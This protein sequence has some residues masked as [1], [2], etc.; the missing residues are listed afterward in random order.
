MA[1]ILLVRHG[2]TDQVSMRLSGRL[3]GILLNEKGRLQAAALAEQLSLAPLLALYSSPLERALQTAAPLAERLGLS[4][5]LLPWL[6]EVDYGTWQGKTYRQLRRQRLWKIL[7]EQPSKSL[8]PGGE[9]LCEAQERMVQGLESLAAACTPESVVACFT[10][11]D[12]IR[13]A[14]AHYLNMALDDY[15]RL[16][17]ST[18]SITALALHAGSAHLL[19]YNQTV[20]LAWPILPGSPAL[21]PAEPAPGEG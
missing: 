15:Q 17:I 3:P 2:E 14:V 12:M 18:A 20:E 4:V 19:C 7:Q 1:I 6:M 13:L 9:S 5:R 16:A 8:F 21:A 10:H 11:G